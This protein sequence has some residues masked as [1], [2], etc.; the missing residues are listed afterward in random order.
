MQLVP[1][2]RFVSGGS[3]YR[4]Q[5]LSDDSSLCMKR[6]IRNRFFVYTRCCCEFDSQLPR[7]ECDSASRILNSL[8][9]CGLFE[10]QSGTASFHISW[11]RSTLIRWCVINQ[12]ERNSAGIKNSWAGA[13]AVRAKAVIQTIMRMASLLLD[14]R[15]R[16]QRQRIHDSRAAL[17]SVLTCQATIDEKPFCIDTLTRI[18]STFVP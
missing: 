6:A 5:L 12:F 15:T 7:G 2:L 14:Q 10:F 11:V 16:G 8:R 17:F 3:G 1:N 18:A 13:G 9:S 4:L